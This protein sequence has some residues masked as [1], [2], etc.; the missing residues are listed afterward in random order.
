MQKKKVK[1][2][3]IKEESKIEFILILLNLSIINLNVKITS[4]R[5][6][7]NPRDLRNSK[8]KKTAKKPYQSANS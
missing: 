6:K 3:L 1:N 4:C 8:T 2:K 7:R 5:L